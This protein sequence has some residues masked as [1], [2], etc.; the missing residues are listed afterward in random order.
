MNLFKSD[1]LCE[2]DIFGKIL[3]TLCREADHYIGRNR[4]IGEACSQF[5]AKLKIILRT[6]VTVHRFECVVTAA[7]K[8]DMK[9][10]TEARKL[11]ESFNHFIGDVVGF[12][13]AETYTAEIQPVGKLNGVTDAQSYIRAVGREVN[14]DQNNLGKAGIAESLK[15]AFKL[16]NR[17]GTHTASRIW[18]NAIGAETVTAVF[19]FYNGSCPAVK[20]GNIAAREFVADLVLLDVDYALAAAEIAVNQIEKS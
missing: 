8:R 20:S 4:R 1:L 18:D 16:V 13:R 14:S 10:R 2:A 19:N 6:V 17:F 15:L 7:L 3:L 9:L 12:K 11:C 5:F